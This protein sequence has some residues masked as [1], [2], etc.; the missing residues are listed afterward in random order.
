MT[1]YEKIAEA[2]KKKGKSVS[3]VSL[4]AGLSRDTI[5]K[6][7]EVSP[8]VKNLRAVSDVLEVPISALIDD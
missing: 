1:T 8:S 5:L 6:W 7:K 3:A 2:A 4:E